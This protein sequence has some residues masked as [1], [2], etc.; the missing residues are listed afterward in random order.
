MKGT[1]NQT[2]ELKAND[3]SVMMVTSEGY[4]PKEGDVICWKGF[5]TEEGEWVIIEGLVFLAM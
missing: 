5:R 1:N 3:C 2:L 4:E